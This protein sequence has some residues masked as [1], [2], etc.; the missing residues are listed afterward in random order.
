MTGL[1]NLMENIT[2]RLDQ[3]KKESVYKKIG[4]LRSFSHRSEKENRMKACEESLW[5]LWDII[6]S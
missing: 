6:N 4:H 2:S 3:E 1:K 5:G